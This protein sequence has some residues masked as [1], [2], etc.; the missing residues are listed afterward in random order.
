MKLLEQFFSNGLPWFGKKKST[1]T[2][3]NDCSLGRDSAVVVKYHS[4]SNHVTDSNANLT[5]AVSSMSYDSN[6]RSYWSANDSH[7]DVF[8]PSSLIRNNQCLNP[9][10][11]SCFMSFKSSSSSAQYSE[12]GDLCD[13]QTIDISETAS[14]SRDVHLTGGSDS[15]DSGVLMDM[16]TRT[17]SI[18]TVATLQQ[19]VKGISSDQLQ[20]SLSRSRFLRNNFDMADNAD[21]DSVT[22]EMLWSVFPILDDEDSSSAMQRSV[23]EISSSLA[24]NIARLRRDKRA[25]E[26]AFSKARS[27]ERLKGRELARIRRLVSDARRSILLGT[28]KQ[29]KKELERQCLRLQAA[30]DTVLSVRWQQLHTVGQTSVA[31]AACAIEKQ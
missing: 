29:L 4:A 12:D 23:N 9:E 27:Q 16:L 14:R 31:D 28:L 6:I 20:T 25:V 3:R 24:A 21:T 13:C 2:E 26:D 11:T 1:T 22:D 10:F 5:L 7:I 15:C 17:E 18:N 8:P 19:D 30:Y